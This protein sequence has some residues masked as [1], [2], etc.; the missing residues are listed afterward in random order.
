[1]TKLMFLRNYGQK[2]AEGGELPSGLGTRH[3]AARGITIAAPVVS[4][5][6]SES[7]A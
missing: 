7:T 1:M 3:A 4:A 2:K 6:I 5:V